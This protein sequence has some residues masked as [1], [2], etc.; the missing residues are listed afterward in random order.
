MNKEN[1]FKLT[2]VIVE[3]VVGS[4]SSFSKGQFFYAN[5]IVLFCNVSSCTYNVKGNPDYRDDD[6]FNFLGS[7]CV[8][9]T[10]LDVYFPG[11]DR[12]AMTDD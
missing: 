11:Q 8:P 4:L 2:T 6:R 5:P 10:E 7:E 1:F 12:V 9:L 3:L